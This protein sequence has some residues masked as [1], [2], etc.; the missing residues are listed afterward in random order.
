MEICQQNTLQKQQN[1]LV[2]ST[3]SWLSDVLWG[4]VGFCLVLVLNSK[5]NGTT[6]FRSAQWW[7]WKDEA[8]PLDE[9]SFVCVLQC[10]DTVG[11][12]TSRSCRL[13]HFFVNGHKHC[14][15]Y[16]LWMQDYGDIWK[17]TYSESDRAVVLHSLLINKVCFMC[18]LGVVMWR[19]H[20]IGF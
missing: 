15:M 12:V 8:S 20:A 4:L 17:D 3:C 19:R 7:I 9:S 10:F 16:Q 5:Q 2:C 13:T 1:S 14:F 11:W 6:T 18:F